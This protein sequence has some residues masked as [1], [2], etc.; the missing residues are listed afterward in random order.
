MIIIRAIG[1]EDERESRQSILSACFD[2][3]D[4]DD[5]ADF[6]KFFPVENENTFHTAKYKFWQ[7]LAHPDFRENV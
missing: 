1:T 4:D 3:D 2:D 7:R 5:T 6:R